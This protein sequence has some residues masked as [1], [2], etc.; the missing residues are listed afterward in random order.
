MKP[1]LTT[2]FRKPACTTRRGRSSVDSTVRATR[3]GVYTGGGG[4]P[5]L[6]VHDAAW[7]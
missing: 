2:G 4:R 6:P 3:C 1:A 7:K 5:V